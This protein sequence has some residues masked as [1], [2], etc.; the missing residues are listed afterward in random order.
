[1]NTFNSSRFKI[2]IHKFNKLNRKPLPQRPQYTLWD[3][4][5]EDIEKQLKNL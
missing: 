4:I 1:M 5:V 2:N 3:Y